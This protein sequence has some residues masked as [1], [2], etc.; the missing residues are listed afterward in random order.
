MHT[1]NTQHLWSVEYI[2]SLHS[3]IGNLASNG[4]AN[5]LFILVQMSTVNMAEPNLYSKFGDFQSFTL[6]N[7]HKQQKYKLNIHMIKRLLRHRLIF[8]RTHFFVCL[9]LVLYVWWCSHDSFPEHC[10]CS[11][12]KSW[13]T[14]W[15]LR[16]Y[17]KSDFPVF[18]Y[19]LE[20]GSYP[21]GQ[22]CRPTISSSVVC[23]IPSK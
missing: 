20:F 17:S 21:L 8:P 13:P 6:R 3:S 11:V 2:F 15:D 9:W 10:C 14:L 23:F 1:E 4:L 22:W 18:H 5:L 7:L 12:T 16:D 19:L